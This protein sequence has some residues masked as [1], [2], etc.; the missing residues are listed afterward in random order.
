MAPSDD[1]AS[2][3]GLRGQ[4]TVAVI[5]SV[6]ASSWTSWS[7]C[8]QATYSNWSSA[9]TSTPNGSEQTGAW[10]VTLPDATST[11]YTAPE[12]SPVTYATV[13]AALSATARGSTA[14]V[15]APPA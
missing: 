10:L 14:G 15:Y 9:P 13:P 4:T 7:S 8:A 5:A 6:L 3:H 1:Q 12:R 2:A 11:A